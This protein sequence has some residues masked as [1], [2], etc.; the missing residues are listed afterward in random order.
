M[1]GREERVVEGLKYV[2]SLAAKKR[3][4]LFGGLVRTSFRL[5]SLAAIKDA[6]SVCFDA[7]GRGDDLFLYPISLAGRYKPVQEIPEPV[8][9]RRMILE[10]KGESGERET[11]TEPVKT[12]PTEPYESFFREIRDPFVLVNLKSGYIEP[13]G[14]TLDLLKL[15]RDD[16]ILHK[17]FQNLLPG[18]KFKLLRAIRALRRKKSDT[19]QVS[20]RREKAIL[21][22]EVHFSVV[23]EDLAGAIIRD[24][25]RTQKEQGRF[26]ALEDEY[27]RFLQGIPDPYLLLRE[28]K[29]I[30]RNRAFSIAFRY[31]ADESI[32]RKSLADICAPGYQARIRE[33]LSRRAGDPPVSAEIELQT[34]DGRRAYCRLSSSSVVYQGAA[35]LQILCID[36][37]A[38]RD[39]REQVARREELFSKLADAAPSPLAILQEGLFRYCNPAF[40]KYF[41]IAAGEEIY[42]R[43]HAVIEEEPIGEWIPEKCSRRNFQKSGCVTHRFT[44]KQTGDER[45]IVEVTVTPLDHADGRLLFSYADV[46]ETARLVGEARQLGMEVDFLNE[47]VT[48][49]HAKGD[50]QKILQSSL[51]KFLDI[52]HWTCGAIYVRGE[53]GKE[54]SIKTS[55]HLPPILHEK[56]SQLP[57]DEGIGGYLAKTKEP[58]LIQVERYPTY[59]AHRSVFRSTDLKTICLIPLLSHESALGIMLLG[60]SGTGG[61]GPVY[62]KRLYSLLGKELGAIIDSAAALLHLEQAVAQYHHLVDTGEEIHYRLTAEGRYEYLSDTVEALLGHAP[63]EFQRNRSLWISLVHPDD[64]RLLLERI[65]RLEE[66]PA[67]PVIEYR[68]MPK[69]KAT[70]LT[71][72]DRLTILRGKDGSIRSLVGT[73]R[74]VTQ[75]KK[76]MQELGETLGERE[77]VLAGIDGPVVVC[78]NDY[79]ISYAN[80]RT[81]EITKRPFHALRGKPVTNLFPADTGEHM[82][83]VMRQTVADGAPRQEEIRLGGRSEKDARYYRIRITVLKNNLGVHSGV[84]CLFTDI[85]SGR[86]REEAIQ[87][88]EQV[89]RNVLDTMGDIVMITDLEGAVQQFNRSF[90]TVLGFSPAEATGCK[91]PYPWLMEEEMGRYVLWIASLREKK[92][93]HDFDMTWQTRDGDRIPVSVSTTLLRGASG[94][95]VGMLNVARDITERI[96][97]MK[98]LEHRNTQ[99][100]LINRIVGKANETNDFE[101]V[102]SLL[103]DE[104]GKLLPFDALSIGLFTEDHTAL[105]MYAVAGT[106]VVKQG[107]R[108][109]LEKTLSRNVLSDARP[110]IVDDLLAEPV[111]RELVSLSGGMRSQL[112]VPILLKGK[113]AGTLNVAYGTQGAYNSSH[114]ELLQPIIQHLGAIIDRIQLFRQVRDDSTY[115]RSL[116]DSVDNIVIT[117]DRDCRIREV[118][119]A[120]HQFVLESGSQVEGEYTGKHLFDVLPDASLRETLRDVIPRLLDGTLAIY[121]DEYMFHGSPAGR[122][123]QITVNPMGNGGGIS[124]LVFTYT[125]ITALKDSESQLR[126]FNDQLLLLTEISSRV[127]TSRSLDEMLDASLPL[128]RLVSGAEAVIV[129]LTRTGSEEL[130]AAM[131]IGFEESVFQSLARLKRNNSLTGTVI[132]MR[133]PLYVERRAYE[134]QRILAHNRQVLRNLSYESM[135]VIPLLSKDNVTGALDFFYGQPTQF[136]EQDRQ[137]LTLV[138]SQLGSAIEAARLYSELRSQIDSLT[139]LYEL[140]QQLTSALEIDRIITIVAQN[141]FRLIPYRR[142]GLMSYDEANP[143]HSVQHEVVCTPSGDVQTFTS[144]PLT[145]FPYDSP[146][147]R[148]ISFRRSF[149][150]E[151]QSVLS[152]PM[153]SKEAITGVITL[154]GAPDE[155]YGE[156]QRY[157]LENVANLAAIALDK[158]KL[159]EETIHISEEIQRR[160]KELDDF[161]YVVS[162]DLK[163]PL[164]SIEGFS[165]I[166]Q[167][168]YRDM[169]QEEGREYLLSIVGATTRMKGLIDDLLLLSRLSRPS[170]AYRSVSMN[171]VIQETLADMKF[172]ITKRNVRFQVPENLPDVW[173][174]EIHLKIV[175]R[176]LIGN[177]IK[178]NDK[179][180]PVVEVGFRNAENNYYLFWVKDNGIGIE[181]EYFGKIFVIFQRLHR[182][183]EY[184]GSGAGLAI[185]KKIIEMH[186]GAIWVESEIG[187]GSTFF[188]TLPMTQLP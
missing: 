172:I 99:I 57:A 187:V 123:Y 36:L 181:K 26:A 94:Q 153:L 133:E 12:E 107:D 18:G 112:C 170:E 40:L 13:N 141:I 90:E 77:A 54:F 9:L 55:R 92:W 20:Y 171:G 150:N 52:F 80:Q 97:L 169:F 78:G 8:S 183:E 168:D 185:V 24:T 164:I 34:G 178:F 10:S 16:F 119:H 159:Y 105:L 106:S 14:E 136:S 49:F 72:L 51:H 100:E 120:G 30:F 61:S 109:P 45:R 104:I 23:G 101:E 47:I 11:E 85:T 175:F 41:G 56:L 167:D 28:R 4:L 179:P 29:I 25:T 17:G 176:N 31:E 158:G 118:N 68:M 174:N 188:L 166:L 117:V 126:R 53:G 69:G 1:F 145:E 58:H 144:T 124:G 37:T 161:T 27:E 21:N 155:P 44:A 102:F 62:A 60:V 111:Y 63:K 116:L 132:D 89:L 137:I 121:S 143:T 7:V 165:R 83:A 147:H 157:T 66:L 152:V 32:L 156:H 110:M 5:S 19:V 113:V 148:A 108:I 35:C 15:G 180:E 74:D 127:S 84:I 163:E 93:L 46:T 81:E 139:A 134:D 64:K 87:N 142:F 146:E 184:E 140:S 182:R 129:Y 160:N 82:L 38:A 2:A 131:Q 50:F 59:L 22:L 177:A 75:E 3:W 91:F 43:P 6:A 67:A 135:A 42:G 76:A 186:K 79:L 70:Y 33:I 130:T 154:H 98:D 115:I 122:I 128:L 39:I 162:H 125:D 151:D 96:R 103:K 138:G 65:T 86:L 88:S 149:I 173:G 71:V 73:V 95:P 114:A 48:T